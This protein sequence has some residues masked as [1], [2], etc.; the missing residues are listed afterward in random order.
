MKYMKMKPRQ[1]EFKVSY[2]QTESSLIQIPFG[3]LE[4]VFASSSSILS[5]KVEIV[6]QWTT[7]SSGH[8]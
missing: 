4:S 2:W 7:Q 8:S 6:I 1:S 3:Q 5:L